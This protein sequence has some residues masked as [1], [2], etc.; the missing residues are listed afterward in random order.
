M[1]KKIILLAGPTASGKSKLAIHLAKKLNGEI[2]NADSMQIY[3]EFSILS[4]R[5][6]KL[7]IKKAKHHLFGMVSVKKYFSAGDWLKETKKKINLCFKKKKTPIIVGGTGLYFNT[8]TKGISKIP[9]IDLK[10]RTQVRNQFKKLGYKKFYEKLLEID[11]KVKGKI[12]PTDSQ[13]TQRAYEV[14]LKTKKSLFDWIANTKSDFL[15]YNLKKIFLD[16]PRQELLQKISKRTEMMFKENCVSEVKKFNSLK[17]NKSL[18]AN[19]LIGVQ[20]I[21]QYL[22][23]IISL[24]ECKEL[25]NIKTRQY[26]KRQNTWARG[27]MKNWNKLYSKNFSIL[28]KKTLKVVS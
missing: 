1:S 14:K 12:L 18:S 20:E 10:T 23:D 26:A 25:I 27:H 8:I 4:S 11:P 7:E 22:K 17:L 16:I 2:I 6:N 19:K 24:D 3:K 21:N 28:L 15:N 9:D 13:R 5:P